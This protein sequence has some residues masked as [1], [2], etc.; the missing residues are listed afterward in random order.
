MN[1][2]YDTTHNDNHINQSDYKNNISEQGSIIPYL[3]IMTILALS[4]GF[5]CLRCTLQNY[6]IT[7]LHKSFLK[8]LNEGLIKECVICLNQ[9]KIDDTIVILPCKHYYHKECISQW[10]QKNKSCPIC[11]IEI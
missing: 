4:F 2:K 7:N 1:N 8:E 5:Q 9:I 11:R 6:N 10:F 3:C